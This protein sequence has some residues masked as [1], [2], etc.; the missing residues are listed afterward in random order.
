MAIFSKIKDILVLC[1]PC[2]FNFRVELDFSERSAQYLH[3]ARRS[4]WRAAAQMR[5]QSQMASFERRRAVSRPG[6]IPLILFC[7]SFLITNYDAVLPMEVWRAR[8]HR[9][10]HE[11][12]L[13]ACPSTLAASSY[14]DTC[15]CLS[16]AYGLILHTLMKFVTT[17]WKQLRTVNQT[18][19]RVRKTS[20]K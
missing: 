4:S 9:V 14:S 1:A 20:N 13:F 5:C 16:L 19:P 15:A 2:G 3:L 11:S 6:F 8:G 12:L 10:R 18:W 17:S 7:P